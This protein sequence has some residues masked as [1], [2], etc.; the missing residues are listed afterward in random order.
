MADLVSDEPV[1]GPYT[2][3]DFVDLDE[4]DR[5]EL[6]DGELVEVDVPNLRHERIVVLLGYYLTGWSHAG[7]GGI[8]VASG[9]KVRITNRRGAMPDVQFYRRGNKSAHEQQRGL[10][11]GRPD[12]VVEIISP[13][14]RRFD[15]V[16]K[17]AW[18]ASR[19]V[20]EY[21]IVDAEAQTVERLVLTGG[22]YAIA[23]SIGENDV[24]KPTSFDGLEMPLARLWAEDSE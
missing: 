18:Y 14:S 2:W 22:I 7:H 24:F 23:Q 4:E 15:R 8:A 20:P 1:R 10:V 17:L 12:L 13:S 16:T 3:A 19:A 11:E 6:V 5:R 9:Y 21:W